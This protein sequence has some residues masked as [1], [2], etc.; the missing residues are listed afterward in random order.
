MLDCHGNPAALLLPSC[1]PASGAGCSSSGEHFPRLPSAFQGC[2]PTP[3]PGSAPAPCPA[4]TAV[5]F[6]PCGPCPRLVALEQPWGGSKA[7]VIVKLPMLGPCSAR[8]PPLPGGVSRA[9]A[10]GS[11]HP[12]CGEPQDTSKQREYVFV[13]KKTPGPR[14]SLPYLHTQNVHYSP[15]SVLLILMGFAFQQRS[16]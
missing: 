10:K 11:F 9:E 2:K 8:L 6:H 15:C 13:H 12:T 14:F 4:H 5:G 1:L 3:F 7:P 16:A